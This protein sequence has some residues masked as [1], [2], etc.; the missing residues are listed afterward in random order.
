[1]S[2]AFRKFDRDRN[3]ILEQGELE[4]MLKYFNMPADRVRD[5]MGVYD[6]TEVDGVWQM[7]YQEF[8]QNFGDVLKAKGE[9]FAD[10][11]ERKVQ[12]RGQKQ[13][14]Q[15]DVSDALL[16]ETEEAHLQLKSQVAQHFKDLNSAFRY[17]DKDKSMSIS[18]AQLQR[19]LNRFNIK[20]STKKLMQ[21]YYDQNG[22]SGKEISYDAFMAIFSQA[23]EAIHYSVDPKSKG[24]VA[25]AMEIGTHKNLH[26]ETMNEQVELM[27]YRNE[28][29]SEDVDEATLIGVIRDHVLQKGRNGVENGTLVMRRAFSRDTDSRGTVHI[30]T[31]LRTLRLDDT[32]RH[33]NIILKAFG[34][35]CNRNRV[36]LYELHLKV[37][38]EEAAAGQTVVTVSSGA[39][40]DE[41]DTTSQRGSSA[42]SNNGVAQ[43]PS[44]SPTSEQQHA[45]GQLKAAAKAFGSRS[46]V[47]QY[48][49]MAR[50][51]DMFTHRG[52]RGALF[53]EKGAFCAA[54]RKHLKLTMEQR[55]LE[56]LCDKFDRGGQ[57]LVSFDEFHSYISSVTQRRPGSAYERPQSAHRAPSVIDMNA[58]F[59]M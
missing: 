56:V 52:A 18:E 43:G 29:A 10:R 40:D 21:R 32:K 58:Q 50:I 23:D 5:L 39:F 20:V 45:L 55:L 36:D 28:Q 59:G 13:A 42:G 24:Y 1:V 16:Q 54:L 17:T 7:D 22:R 38:P 25:N 30:D 44:Q 3:G 31:L 34:D 11:L 46:A 26:Q 15:K 6:S 49:S 35:S 57:G 51:R 33:R 41:S 14:I 9:A 27:K 47:Q 48:R 4:A 37:L 2:E 53:A 8:E 12:P 19:V